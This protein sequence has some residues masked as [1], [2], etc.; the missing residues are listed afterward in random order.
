MSCVCLCVCLPL[1]L[2]TLACP[3]PGLAQ[4]ASLAV[5][6]RQWV[7]TALPHSL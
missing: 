6:K 4:V 2:F 1:G 7:P 3:A 5:T